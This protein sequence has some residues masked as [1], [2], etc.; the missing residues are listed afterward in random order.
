MEN[1]IKIEDGE[2]TYDEDDVWHPDPSRVQPYSIRELGQPVVITQKFDSS[3]YN[4]QSIRCLTAENSEVKVEMRGSSV[5][6]PAQYIDQNT[7]ITCHFES[8]LKEI[9]AFDIDKSY[10][11]IIEKGIEISGNDVNVDINTPE[12]IQV[13]IVLFDRDNPEQR[14]VG[15]KGLS[16][17]SKYNDPLTGE[18][19]EAIEGENG[20]YLFTIEATDKIGED[21]LIF[22]NGSR[23]SKQSITINYTD[24]LEVSP[25]LN[26]AVYKDTSGEG[27]GN[28][29]DTDG[30]ARAVVELWEVGTTSNIKLT[31]KT[32]DASGKASFELPAGS[33]LDAQYYVR[34]QPVEN[35]V[36]GTRWFS[37]QTWA[38]ADVEASSNAVITHMCRNHAGETTPV[39]SD[40]AQCYAA[41]H[42]D[43][44]SSTDP[45][46]WAIYSLVETKGST[47]EI[48]LAFAVSPRGNF[49]SGNFAD[50]IFHF[51]PAPEKETQSLRLGKLVDSQE[52]PKKYDLNDPQASA[53]YDGVW[54]RIKEG[55]QAFAPLN[56]MILTAGLEYE[57]KVMLSGAA[58][59]NA[60][61]NA[62]TLTEGGN[63]VVVVSE[64][65]FGGQVENDS[66]FKTAD[67]K[68]RYVS[69]D[70]LIPETLSATTSFMRF[71]YSTEKGLG[72]SGDYVENA[73]IKRIPDGEVE[74]Y[75]L[76]VVADSNAFDPEKSIITVI[77]ESDV[78][79]DGVD[80][81][82]VQVS[83]FHSITKLPLTGHE[84]LKLISQDG[85][86][87]GTQEEIT[88]DEQRAAGIYVFTISTDEVGTDTIGY[89]NF[90]PATVNYIVGNGDFN[91]GTSTITLADGQLE[92][93]VINRD[94][95][96]V[97]VALFY[98]N[99]SAL[100]IKG[101]DSKKLT[102]VSQNEN[103][104]VGAWDFLG[105]TNGV[106]R[107]TVK[108]SVVGDDLL[109]FAT[110][111][112]STKEITDFTALEL[113][114][115]LGDGF[116]D[117]EKSS[118][119]VEGDADITADG[120]ATATVKVTL[121][122]DGTDLPLAGYNG[123]ALIAQEGTL[124]GTQTEIT[125]A[126][127]RAAGI[128]VFTVSS[129][130][131]GTDTLGFATAGTTTKDVAGFNAATVNY[132]VGN[133]YFAHP[134]STIEVL[135]GI[136]SITADGV[137]S[138]TIAVSLFHAN[139]PSLPLTGYQGLMLTTQMRNGQVGNV[140]A[141]VE[142]E[143]Q[144]GV[145]HF[146]VTSTVVGMDMFHFATAVQVSDAQPISLTYDHGAG[147]FAELESTIE[148]A[149]ELYSEIIADDI[150]TAKVTV[151]LF[152]KENPSVVISGY[153]ALRLEPMK[154]TQLIGSVEGPIESDTEP[155][156]YYFML[157]SAMPGKDQ[158]TFATS[159]QVSERYVTVEYLAG[160]D[161]D[162]ALS[163]IEAINEKGEGVQ[164]AEIKADGIE[165]TRLRVKPFYATNTQ[166]VITGLTVNDLSL[167]AVS[168][169][170]IGQF[171]PATPFESAPGEYQFIV[172]SDA[173]GVDEWQFVI[174]DQASDA[175]AMVTYLTLDDALLQIRLSANG[176]D[177]RHG[178]LVVIIADLKN[179]GTVDA[180]GLNLLNTLPAGMSYVADSAVI[181]KGVGRSRNGGAPLSIGGNNPLNLS[182]ISIPIGSEMKIHYAIRVGA[183]A[184]AGTY[185]AYAE[186]FIEKEGRLGS[187]SN[188]ASVVITVASDPMMSESLILGTVYH[189]RNG[190]G[191]QDPGEPGIPGVR[192]VSA[193]GLIIT[194]DQFG[195]YHLTGIDGGKMDRGRNFILKVDPASLPEGVSF[196]SP[197]PLVRR[198]TPGVPVRFDFGVKVPEKSVLRV[199]DKLF[200]EGEIAIK[201]NY[202]KALDQMVKAI[203]Q[204][205]IREVIITTD[206]FGV[207]SEQRENL[208]REKLNEKLHQ[209]QQIFVGSQGSKGDLK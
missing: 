113:N 146:I 51:N 93:L 32:T 141:A 204:K 55:D 184:K 1:K 191:M 72:F 129:E 160:T 112:K 167:Q 203:E 8:I 171:M 40:G 7:D 100:P 135:E 162:Q 155:G 163:I 12:P 26:V 205:E 53:Q 123:L 154:D 3:T 175:K 101:Y 15:Y 99:N 172:S 96:I 164:Q 177:I 28:Y 166:K 17:G 117:T 151:K 90:T 200:I 86:L 124:L 161:F 34:L 147:D 202:M 43:N 194:T 63:P 110:E 195:R 192:I 74:D 186:G 201:P 109:G 104:L 70:L 142:Q 9:N 73:N 56:K 33:T 102:L 27:L 116:F 45:K 207:L 76:T 115:H 128:Y 37:G 152:H 85:E 138:A 2:G 57:F 103:D 182:N 20:E 65:T 97:E 11:R 5:T 59:D 13:K 134:E 187:V 145:Y 95:T 196:L 173:V 52:S 36:G 139:N 50:G 30:I 49:G 122:H 35:N 169:A 108:S 22:Y 84:G 88:T 183:A 29:R 79:A 78:I 69:F 153:T 198:I 42:Q 132:V 180:L 158:F 199:S 48:N 54:A 39:V 60:T 193:E 77:G 38:G 125:T 71:R 111:A 127:Q 87:L 18:I 179:I 19:S 197:N 174:K 58:V 25:L 144:P 23:K 137:D 130:T 24:G 120:V 105:E 82:T 21:I 47:E 94:E 81:A 176:N 91:A 10:M 136:E 185:S 80:K 133:G 149:G 66:R 107:F 188:R 31:E 119:E 126:E 68:G 165:T 106:Y 89:D 121:I 208:L 16:L 148:I 4:L 83:L 62:W 67:G 159:T 157:K 44:P 168:G 61:L 170:A 150:D 75:A 6:I 206:T 131:V 209:Q 189:D 41:H 190:N 156:T 178:D 98:A 143:N 64:L 118:I 14:L 140:S 46:E 181:D 92:S 114:Y